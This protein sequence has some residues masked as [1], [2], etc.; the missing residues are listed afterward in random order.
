MTNEITIKQNNHRLDVYVKNSTNISYGFFNVIFLDDYY[1]TIVQN[2]SAEIQKLKIKLSDCTFEILKQN[3]EKFTVTTEILISILE[4][5]QKG[6]SYIEDNKLI[7]IQRKFTEE[8]VSLED[9]LE[10]YKEWYF[11]KTKH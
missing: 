5:I 6:L 2:L 3:N 8:C 7:I 11:K 1:N 4:S 10:L 9:I